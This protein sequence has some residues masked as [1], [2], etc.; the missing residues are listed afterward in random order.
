[1]NDLDFVLQLVRVARFE[2]FDPRVELVDPLRVGRRCNR[3]HRDRP[4]LLLDVVTH[5]RNPMHGLFD[6][7]PKLLLLAHGSEDAAR[8]PC[9]RA[10]R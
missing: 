6:R 1:M 8:A 2:L 3:K 10:S 9:P 4:V 7:R 5:P